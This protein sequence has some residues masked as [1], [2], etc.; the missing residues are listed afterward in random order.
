MNLSGI[1]Y[2]GYGVGVPVGGRYREIL[3]TDAAAYGGR[4][5]GN[6]GFVDAAEIPMHGKPVSI[7]SYL[8]PQSLILLMPA[9]LKSEPAA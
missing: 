4:D 5:R 3:N 7:R 8:P 6:F 9:P 1:G 2:E